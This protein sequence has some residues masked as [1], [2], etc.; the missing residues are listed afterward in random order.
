MK[1]L[2][3]KDS[4][5]WLEQ[6]IRLGVFEKVESFANQV[7]DESYSQELL[8]ENPDKVDREGIISIDIEEISSSL[9]NTLTIGGYDD[10]V[11][12]IKTDER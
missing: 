3:Q 7:D 6:I 8:I 5:F 11:E 4:E 12:T 1:S 10:N 2:L 9:S